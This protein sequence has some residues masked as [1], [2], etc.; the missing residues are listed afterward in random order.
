MCVEFTEEEIGEQ[1][2]RAPARRT[3]R[4]DD[5]TALLDLVG[6]LSWR[7]A[8]M[9][10]FVDMVHDL[11]G[12]G[13]TMESVRAAVRSCV[14]EPV[15]TRE[16]RRLAHQLCGSLVSPDVPALFRFSAG[17]VGQMLRS[18]PANLYAVLNELE[19]L[20]VRS[21]DGLHPVVVFVECLAAEQPPESAERLRSWVDSCVG[22]RT[23][24]VV[25]LNAIRHR[26]PGP[27][28]PQPK[29]FI[30]QLDADG[31]DADR[32][33]LSVLFQEG[34]G[35]FEPLRPPD[36]QSYTE[37]EVRALIGQALN[38]QRLAGALAADL[39]IEFFLPAQLI[40]QPVDQ[41]HVGMGDIML[42]V[43][44]PIVIRSLDRIRHARNSHAYWKAKWARIPEVELRDVDAAV[45]WL[46]G[47]AREQ[48]DRLFVRLTDPAAPVCLF[49]TVTPVPSQCDALL[50]ALMAGVPV[51]L[52]CRQPSVDIR[53]GLSGLMTRATP[54]R[55][56]DL[57][58]DVYVFRRD[59]VSGRAGPEHI[60]H[61]L[62]LMWDDADRIPDMGNPLQ[63]P[64]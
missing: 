1:L 30:V 25:A 24:L 41:W 3:R 35:P 5:R 54:G 18:D 46:P 44:Y 33:L 9:W 51:L 7:D 27:G 36:D 29:Y 49:L 50:A 12:Q 57:P 19:D 32:F 47:D 23:P 11:Y 48:G 4:S 10:V 6:R 64:A 52:W 15:L 16:R 17:G 2:P 56:R 8:A 42:G 14:A 63:M 43:Q 34:T 21:E 60:A 58:W 38:E 22:N 61:H 13:E 20:P 31:V 53:A 62:T 39:T 37:A 40:N 26:H 45:A 59:A 28:E 55:L